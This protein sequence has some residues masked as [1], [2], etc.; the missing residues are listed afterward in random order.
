MVVRLSALRTGRLYHQE[1]PPVLISVTGLSRPHGHSAIWRMSMKKSNDTIWYRTSDL[2]ICSTALETRLHF[3][4]QLWQCTDVPY[5]VIIII[6]G[7]GGEKTTSPTINQLCTRCISQKRWSISTT[8]GHFPS[9]MQILSW[10]IS[11]QLAYISYQVNSHAALLVVQCFVNTQ[12]L[13]LVQT[14]T[15]HAN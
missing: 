1:M 10:L 2:P 4:I 6:M 12:L 7:G 14:Y 3:N 9:A 13:Q 5:N 15:V 8:H 11:F